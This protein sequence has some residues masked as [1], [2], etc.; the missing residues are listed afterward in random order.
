MEPRISLITLGVRDLE[1]A[2]RFYR[3][4]LGWPLAAL[5]NENVSFFRTTG[6][7]LSL[8]SR[9]SLAEDAGVPAEGSGFPGFTLAYNVR[10]REEV[11]E[12]LARAVDA[13]GTLVKAARDVF[14]GGH[15]GYFADPEGTLWE[16]A[17]NPYIPFAEDGTLRLE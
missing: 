12:V 4:G 14:W 2:T 11:S 15:C 5:S 6:V 3:D 9:E 1:R 7:V 10:R 13:G 17:W 16:V 8:F